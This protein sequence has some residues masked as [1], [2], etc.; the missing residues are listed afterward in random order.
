[1]KSIVLGN[2]LLLAAMLVGPLLLATESGPRW[3][4]VRVCS[5]TMSVQE[6]FP[7]SPAALAGIQVG[8][9]IFK[10]HGE[11][12]PDD[13][14]DDLSSLEPGEPAM[15]IV[16]KKRERRE[17]SIIPTARPESSIVPGTEIFLT[18]FQSMQ[19]EPTDPRA[20]VDCGSKCFTDV[21]PCEALKLEYEGRDKVMARWRGSLM[22]FEGYY[23]GRIFTDKST[24]LAETKAR[25]QFFL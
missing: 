22:T 17:V 1:M 13:I 23:W 20:P 12:N 19:V 10:V 8:E 5:K 15:V 9:T 3:I 7:G 18:D 4:G 24:C 21:G 16:G 14:L 2:S 25:C 11:S 6:V